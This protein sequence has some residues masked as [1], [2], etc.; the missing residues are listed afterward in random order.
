PTL[1][2]GR[3][4]VLRELRD[5]SHVNRFRSGSGIEFSSEGLNIVFGTNGAGKSGYS[6][7]LKRACRARRSTRV[8]PDVFSDPPGTP[9]A[10]VVVQDEHAMPEAHNWCEGTPADNRLAMVAVYDSQ[11]GDDYVS[12]EGA[13]NYQP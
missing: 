13:C 1:G 12:K 4:T 9:S 5:L 2:D 7:V 11:C 10:V 8:L 3:T 6:R